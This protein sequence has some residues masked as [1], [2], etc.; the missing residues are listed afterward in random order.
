MILDHG[1][2]QKTFLKAIDLNLSELEHSRSVASKL[3][4]HET[5]TNSSVRHCS[6]QL[7]CWF[8]WHLV[9][10]WESSGMSDFSRGPLLK[11]AE[12]KPRRIVIRNKR[13]KRG[14]S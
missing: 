9:I 7:T 12:K 5:L 10:P 2:R 4:E 6:Q 14:I 11:I 13:H 3:I 8:K 1:N